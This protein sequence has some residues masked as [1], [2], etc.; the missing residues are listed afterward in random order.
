MN[1]KQNAKPL[2]VAGLVLAG[3]AGTTTLAATAVNA[4]SNGDSLVEKIASKFNLNKSDVQAVFD[5]AHD[6][7]EAEKQAEFSDDL[8]DKVDSGDITAEQKTLIEN[9]FKELQVQRDSNRQ[10]LE[11]WAEQNNID[12]KYLYM[13]HGRGG[14]DLQD[15][16]DDGDLT[17]E[18]K[19]LIENK[20][21]E[22][23]D[24]RSA[25]RD[26]LE[27]WASDNNLDL[28]DIMPMGRGHGRKMGGGP[29]D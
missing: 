15:A 24:K 21:K 28:K 8:Q 20:Q 10:A 16:V 1:I 3:I 5:E 26:E 6:E 29:R 27:K 4:Q 14:S 12:A 2:L 11:D 17:S 22:L 13:G 19:T 25:E 7:H 18:Q 9:K 23:E